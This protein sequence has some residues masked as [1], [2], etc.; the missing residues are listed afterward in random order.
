MEQT[1]RPSREGFRAAGIYSASMTQSRWEFKGSWGHAD[2]VRSFK[3]I[4][5]DPMAYEL[6]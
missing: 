6:D 5:K 2:G 4:A 1:K 3:I